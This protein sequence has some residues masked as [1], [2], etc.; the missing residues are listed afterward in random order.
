VDWISHVWRG[1]ADD[2]VM[3]LAASGDGVILDRTF[4]SHDAGQ[5]WTY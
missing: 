5:S 3:V 2:G 1:P 4:V